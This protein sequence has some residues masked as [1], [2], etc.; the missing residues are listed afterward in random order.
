MQKPPC[1]NRS[2][3]HALTIYLHYPV[4]P[5]F[6]IG[7]V[8]FSEE[9][10]S[11]EQ[12]CTF[13]CYV[14]FDCS[15]SLYYLYTYPGHMVTSLNKFARTY[16]P[17]NFM[18]ETTFTVQQSN[19]GGT[20]VP[21]ETPLTSRPLLQVHHS[22]LLDCKIPFQEMPVYWSLFSSLPCANHANLYATQQPPGTSYIT[23]SIHL[24]IK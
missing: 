18:K 6:S 13:C 19:D 16:L 20:N 2:V 23:G 3:P 11:M 14:L 8:V 21:Q 24:L 1:L 9:L 22:V 12:G 17:C 7:R 10:Y 4:S 15:A 5:Y